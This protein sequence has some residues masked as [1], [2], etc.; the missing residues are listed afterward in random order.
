MHEDEIEGLLVP[1]LAR[2]GADAGAERIGAL[3][4]RQGL[5]R[6]SFA[7]LSKAMT[8]AREGGAA[9]RS[10]WAGR[11]L[12]E[13]S[14]V[15]EKRAT[16]I[17]DASPVYAARRKELSRLRDLHA[18]P[19]GLAPCMPHVLAAYGRVMEILRADFWQNV[20]R[21]MGAQGKYRCEL[22]SRIPAIVADIEGSENDSEAAWF[23]KVIWPLLCERKEDFVKYDKIKRL[24]DREKVRREMKKE[25]SF[26]TIQSDFRKAWRT[27]YRKPGGRLVGIERE[28][29]L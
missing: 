26:S 20:T 14:T 5:E 6:I 29:A 25:D 24:L 28:R 27:L 17:S 4:A 9:G 3:L 2:A 11:F 15:L 19:S 18:K 1:L 21:E 13:L 12:A 16:W 10:A 23:E 22:E 7:V 8:W